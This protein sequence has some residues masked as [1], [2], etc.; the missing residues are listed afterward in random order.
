MLLQDLS[1]LVR[2]FR[3]LL[4]GSPPHPPPPPARCPPPPLPSAIRASLAA[5]EP[6]IDA[7][8]RVSQAC[9]TAPRH[10]G[11]LSQ[12]EGTVRAALRPTRFRSA[13]P[14]RPGRGE[15]GSRPRRLQPHALPRRRHLGSP[16]APPRPQRAA[17]GRPAGT[18]GEGGSEERAES[19]A[20]ARRSGCPPSLGRG[21]SPPHSQCPWEG[22]CAR[23]LSGPRLLGKRARAKTARRHTRDR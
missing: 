5:P 10:Q 13:E 14:A 11:G 16:T 3:R 19:R 22:L 2:G 8:P 18:G 15:G 7:G 4:P 20:P 17:G 12:S 6:R 1:P 9:V 23:D 21:P